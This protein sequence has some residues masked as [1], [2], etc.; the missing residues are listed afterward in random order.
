MKTIREQFGT[1][2]PLGE[3]LEYENDFRLA[4]NRTPEIEAEQAEV[5]YE[6]GFQIALRSLS[7]R[8]FETQ[9]SKSGK[10]TEKL[11]S[12]IAKFERLPEKLPNLGSKLNNYGKR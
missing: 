1:D 7:S 6:A 3:I 4:K 2:P 5:D 12:V 9:L 10:I 8:Q 11:Q